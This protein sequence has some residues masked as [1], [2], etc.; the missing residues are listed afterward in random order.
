MLSHK[1]IKDLKLN[2]LL[3]LTK[4]INNNLSV[5]QII[6][7]YEDF[8][9]TKLN[10]PKLC[11]FVRSEETWN[12]LL[13]FGLKKNQKIVFE[14]ELLEITEIDTLTYWKGHFSKQFDVVVPIYHKKTALAYVL[15]GDVNKES[16]GMSPVI[17]HLPF[18][19]TLTNIIVVAI[20]NKRLHKKS[21]EQAELNKEIELAKNI[22]T[23]LFPSN[24]PYNN[25]I[26]IFAKYIPHSKVGGDYYDLIQINNHEYIFC[27]ADVSGKGMAAA[28][29]MS[30]LQAALHSIVVFT[31]NLKDIV[32]QLNRRIIE[33]A[34]G[35]K[36]ISL[37]IGKVNT[38]SK[39][40]ICIN[41]GH[42]PPILI[43]D[44]KEVQYLTKG[45]TLLGIIKDLGD[46][47]V[48]MID[49]KNNFLLM[50]YTD[51]LSE[52]LSDL[53]VDI[54]D[55]G[56]FLK[57]NTSDNLPKIAQSLLEWPKRINHQSVKFHD[58]VALMLIASHLS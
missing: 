18:I 8:L 2:A 16:I 15:L 34:K 43:K 12:C 30:N 56:R 44:K 27:I 5:Q 14:E 22:Q 35:E 19:Q 40:I 51:G 4:A 6:D 13:H 26:K 53:D 25:S 46:I 36:F 39:Q 52:L 50:L 42:N 38:L 47:D 58:D 37:F 57:R 28:L 41:A 9:T 24:L 55:M 7:L 49:Y 48:S 17:R 32:Y 45:T 10:I 11:L 20:E 31:H 1:E 21:I 54:Q 3:Q 23:L 33:S 29:L